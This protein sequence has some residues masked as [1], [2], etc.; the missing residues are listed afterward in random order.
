M[1]KALVVGIDAYPTSPLS[2]CVN[3]AVSFASTLEKNG[4][5]SPNF[6]IRL[7]TSNDTEVSSSLLSREVRSLFTGDAD[8]ALF[9]FRRAR[10]NQPR[11]QRWLYC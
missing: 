9:F 6:S 10:N 1:K 7:L 11:Y 4:D 5:G 3:D 8:T 2:G